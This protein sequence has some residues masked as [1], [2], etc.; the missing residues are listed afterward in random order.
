MI[1]TSSICVTV[2]IRAHYGAQRTSRRSRT[3]HMVSTTLTI[4]AIICVVACCKEGNAVGVVKETVVIIC[5]FA[6]AIM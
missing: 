5:N 1:V 6:Y 3:I 4:L 2:G